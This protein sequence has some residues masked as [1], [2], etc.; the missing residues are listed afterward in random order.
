MDKDR[1]VSLGEKLEGLVGD[2]WQTAAQIQRLSGGETLE[3]AKM[4]DRLWEVG[5]IDRETLD[6]GI[7]AKR[8]GGGSLFRRIRYRRKPSTSR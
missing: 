1:S 5:R 8:R 2:E 6:I 7:G 3:V 4:L